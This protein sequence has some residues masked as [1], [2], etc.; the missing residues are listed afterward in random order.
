MLVGGPDTPIQSLVLPGN[1]RVMA[2]AAAL[3]E[4]GMDCR[5]VRSPTVPAGMERIRVVL[6]AHNARDGVRELAERLRALA[7][8]GR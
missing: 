2:V 1:E 3:R 8:V 6:H 4:E 5:A 7:V